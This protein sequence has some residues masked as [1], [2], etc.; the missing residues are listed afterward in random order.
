[1][2]RGPKS[3]LTSQLQKHICESLEKCNTTKTAAAY[4]NV[5]ERSVFSWISTNPSFAAAVS[6]ARAKAKAKLVKVIVDASPKD[7]RAAC[8][9]LERSYPG[10]YARTETRI[11]EQKAEE[12]KMGAVPSCITSAITH[13]PNF[14]TSRQW[15]THRRSPPKNRGVCLK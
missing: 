7:F 5:S 2:K 11:I 6:R 14:W 9:L 15:M 12:Q 10:E 3:I 4:C 8:W 1:M 13:S